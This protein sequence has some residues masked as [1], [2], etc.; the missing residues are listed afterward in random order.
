MESP[1]NEKWSD[2][3]VSQIEQIAVN[4][5][6]LWFHKCMILISQKYGSVTVDQYILGELNRNEWIAYEKIQ[7]DNLVR[8]FE[9]KTEFSAKENVVS[10]YKA[11][12]SDP[13]FT[14][15]KNNLCD[16]AIDH[17]SSL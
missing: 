8:I 3:R 13:I 7:I 2:E 6:R 11:T 1:S 10:R 12:T 9:G 14:Y 17:F 5:Q 16:D 4:W 15:D